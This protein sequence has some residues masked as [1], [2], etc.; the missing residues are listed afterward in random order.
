MSG[1]LML[2]Q[3]VCEVAVRNVVSEILS[4]VNEAQWPWAI[5]FERSLPDPKSVF[6]MRMG[7]GS[8]RRKARVGNTNAAISELK[9]AF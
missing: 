3:Q 1:A 5:G 4:L 8:A 2:P 7:L 9:F 6:S